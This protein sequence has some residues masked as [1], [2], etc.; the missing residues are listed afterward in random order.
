MA[1]IDGFDGAQQL[2]RGCFLG[3]ISVRAGLD[4]AEDV[5][6]VA[7]HR[8]HQYFDLWRFL[9]QYFGD[10]QAIHARHTDV[11]QHDIRGQFARLAQGFVAIAGLTDN[12]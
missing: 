6:L 10:R 9:P 2:L 3:Y 11:H 8:Q 4:D 12:S 1:L 5:L 7:M